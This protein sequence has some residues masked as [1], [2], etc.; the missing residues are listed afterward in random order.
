MRDMLQLFFVF[1]ALGQIDIQ[2]I[3][4]RFLSRQ[5]NHH[6]TGI[7]RNG[8]AV[9]PPE[10]K[11]FGG[12]SNPVFGK[13]LNFLE[14]LFAYRLRDNQVK[15]IG[16]HCFFAAISVNPLTGR[17]P[18]ENRSISGVAL[19]GNG[20]NILENTAQPLIVISQ[21]LLHQLALG[22]VRMRAEHALRAS[23]AIPLRHAP[24]AQYPLVAAIPATQAL[25]GNILIAEFSR[26]ISFHVRNSARLVF[27]VQQRFQNIRLMTD[28]LFAIA[29]HACIAL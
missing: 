6:R 5:S 14:N 7:N 1:L 3:H 13:I 25:L 4:Y 27:R 23:V 9:F 17:I 18:V 8:T 28:F 24:P 19:H 16:P 12:R 10:Q 26:Q 11:L 29:Q 20:R 2:A 21:S 15:Q 22:D